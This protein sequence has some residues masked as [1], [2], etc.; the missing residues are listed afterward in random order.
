MKFT[1]YVVVRDYGK[2]GLA[3]FSMTDSA[4]L[5]KICCWSTMLNYEGYPKG[6]RPGLNAP[7][8][9][10]EVDRGYFLKGKLVRPGSALWR[11]LNCDAFIRR[12]TVFA[13]QGYE[14]HG[15]DVELE[16]VVVQKDQQKYRNER[17]KR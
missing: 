12:Y 5:G 15:P 14:H 13:V 1:E 7:Y 3:L 8:S 4:N 2:Q 16:I 10:D 9:Y 6:F 17:W 11:E